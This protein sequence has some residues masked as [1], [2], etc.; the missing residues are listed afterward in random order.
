METDELVFSSHN[1]WEH[2]YL[3]DLCLFCV[4]P[5]LQDTAYYLGIVNGGA[6]DFLIW[7]KQAPNENQTVHVTLQNLKVCQSTVYLSK[8]A[9]VYLTLIN[10]SE[11]T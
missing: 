1:C 3:R 4:I 9:V 7:Q 6:N 5:L 11:I 8:L 2:Q 10:L